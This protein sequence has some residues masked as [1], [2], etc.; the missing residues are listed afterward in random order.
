[1]SPRTVM[2]VKLWSVYVTCARVRAISTETTRTRSGEPTSVGDSILFVRAI[3]AFVIYFRTY[4]VFRLIGN[5]FWR[6]ASPPPPMLNDR[7]DGRS[8]QWGLCDDARTSVWVDNKWSRKIGKLPAPRLRGMPILPNRSRARRT[9]ENRT[10]VPVSGRSASI[11]ARNR[12]SKAR[13]RPS[14]L[15]TTGPPSG[16]RKSQ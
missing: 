11:P 7:V 12:H 15:T 5:D 3:R 1:M 6:T 16:F 4:V 8:A 2:C 14:R 9:F 10:L 13:E